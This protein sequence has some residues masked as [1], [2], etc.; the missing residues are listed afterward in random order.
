MGRVLPFLMLVPMFAAACQAATP[1]VAPTSPSSATSIPTAIPAP[2]TVR[3]TRTPAPSPTVARRVVA[4]GFAFGPDGALYVSDCGEGVVLHLISPTAGEPVV[5]GQAIT[6]DG[7]GDGGPAIKANV[8]CPAGL[9][10]DLQG[11]LLVTD[12]G[13]NR[14]RRVESDGDD[15]DHRRRQSPP[16]VNRG[17]FGD[18]GPGVDAA[19]N[20]PIGLTVAADGTLYIA[21]RENDRVRVVSPDGRIDTLAGQRG[22]H[23]GG[24]GGRATEA[25]IDYPLSTAVDAAGNVYIADYNHNRIREVTPDGRISTVIGDG[26]FGSGGDGGPAVKAQLNDPQG[27]A[28]DA[29]GNIYVSESGEGANRIRRID[30]KTGI[31]TLFAGTGGDDADKVGVPA[32]QGELSGSGPAHDRTV[33]RAVRRGPGVRPHPAHR[34]RHRDALRRRRRPGRDCRPVS[35]AQRPRLW[36]RRGGMMASPTY[37]ARPCC[38]NAMSAGFWT[39]S[40]WGRRAPVGAPVA[41]G[42]VGAIW[43]LDTEAGGWAVKEVGALRRGELRSITEG[44]AFQEAALSRYSG[45]PASVRR[46]VDGRLIADTGDARRGS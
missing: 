42:R 35:R 8:V 39:P 7:F 14:I 26:S 5:D 12:H 22:D 19:L 37:G 28:I 32:P 6:D 23:F 18:G 16:Y 3:P 38:T 30:P 36:A 41:S 15:H 2:V 10:I 11:R 34:P 46:T 1:P 45:V 25:D 31:V 21:D 13:H 4:G 33:R 29:D 43:R 40:R 24:D 44:A 17:D 20:A 9:A 27:V